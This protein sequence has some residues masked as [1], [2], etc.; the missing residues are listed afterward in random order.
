MES[1][2]P[3]TFANQFGGANPKNTNKRYAA[4]LREYISGGASTAGT[5]RSYVVD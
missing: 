5:K 1:V 3:S 2:T 4:N